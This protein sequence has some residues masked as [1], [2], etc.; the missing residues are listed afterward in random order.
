MA[1]KNDTFKRMANDL[2]EYTH[3]KLLI[4]DFGDRLRIACMVLRGIGVTHGDASGILGDIALISNRYT[5]LKTY[6]DTLAVIRE[7]LVFE[8]NPMN[9]RVLALLCEV[10]TGYKSIEAADRLIDSSHGSRVR[11]MQCTARAHKDRQAVSQHVSP[12]LLSPGWRPGRRGSHQTQ[13][14]EGSRQKT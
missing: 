1:N 3:N 11:S 14:E 6:S 7:N 4:K 8:Q 5:R 13:Q 12:S 2:P 10:I 9:G